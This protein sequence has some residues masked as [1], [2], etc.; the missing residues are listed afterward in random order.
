MRRRD[1]ASVGFA[2]AAL[3]VSVFAVGGVPRWAQAIVAFLLAAALVP[4]MRSRRVLDRMSPLMVLL[5]I[6]GALT[7]IQLLPL[8]GLADALQPIGSRLRADGTALLDVSSTSAVTLDAPATLRGLAYIAILLAVAALVLRA[9]VSER[10]RFRVLGVVSIVCGLT[11][12][13]SGIHAVIGAERLFGLYA[14]KSAHPALL[15]PLLNDNHLGCLMAIGTVV[16]VGL[17]MYGRQASWAR[18]AWLGNAALCGAATGASESRGA[19]IALGVGL[20]TAVAIR[21]G[22]RLTGADANPQRRSQFVTSALPIAVVAICTIVVVIYMTAGSVTEELT[23]TTLEEA[24]KPMSKFEAWHSARGLVEESPWLGIGRGAL[25]PTF[26]RVHPASSLATYAYLEN[27]YIQAIVDYGIPGAFLL[28]VAGVWVMVTALRRWREGPLAAG[29]L[30]AL[31][32]VLIQSNVDFGVELIGVAVPVVAIAATMTFVPLREVSGRKLLVSRFI[33]P[34]Q[35]AALVGVGLLMLSSLTTT[36]AEDHEALK[37]PNVTAAEIR[38]SVARHPLDYYGY[39]IAAQQALKADDKRAISLLNHAMRLHPTHSGL[40]LLAARLL[41]RGKRLDQATIEYSAAIRGTQNPKPLLA[42]IVRELPPNLAAVAIPID[43][44]LID[45]VLLMLGE[46][47]RRDIAA[48]VAQRMLDRNTSVHTCELFFSIAAET[49]DP[50]V[51]A[52]ARQRCRD[53]DPGVDM[54]MQLARTLVEA[55]AFTEVVELLRDVEDWPGRI[56]QKISAWLVL[57][58]AHIALQ[59]WDDAT[60]CLR[61]LQTSGYVDESALAEVARRFDDIQQAKTKLTP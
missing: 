10:G 13:V 18:A 51:I 6:A 61:R 45:A 24:S 21:L 40:H 54:R 29:A 9:S 4:Q 47:N 56:D 37:A 52:L 49:R 1:T 46:L 30:G 15:G 44:P 38:E 60:R 23:K 25:E 57:C 36:L 32:A 35:I 34:A 55:R 26:T 28:G 7:L 5:G 19:L 33:R 12:L 42:E 2:I 14:P 39:A 58:D 43:Y 27:E 53:F 8:G 50:K 31:A 22:Q 59:R 16:A 48:L 11:A 41:L 17:A 3:F 20:L